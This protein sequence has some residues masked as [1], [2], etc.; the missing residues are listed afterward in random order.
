MERCDVCLIRT[1]QKSHDGDKEEDRC[2]KLRLQ[3]RI[4]LKNLNQYLVR[5]SLGKNNEYY[6]CFLVTKKKSF[7]KKRKSGQSTLYF[8]FT[9]V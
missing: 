7:F 4:G 6:F 9:H 5:A 8:D 3:L 2:H 1:N